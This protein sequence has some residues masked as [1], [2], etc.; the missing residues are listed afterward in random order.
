MKHQIKT[1]VSSKSTETVQTAGKTR[2]QRGKSGGLEA[3]D[4]RSVL[5]AATFIFLTGTAGTGGVPGNLA[6]GC[7]GRGEGGKRGAGFADAA[8][9]MH[10]KTETGEDLFDA[11]ETEDGGIDGALE[12]FEPKVALS[13][14][15]AEIGEGAAEGGLGLAAGAVDG[16][17]EGS[18]FAE[19][20]GI[21]GGEGGVVDGVFG[22]EIETAGG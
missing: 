11:G 17:L 10:V 7:R 12:G 9:A 5:A 22:L 6:G 18:G 16:G 21:A 3:E 19:E 1:V 2:N 8:G 20:D 14:E 15:T 13:L 4:G